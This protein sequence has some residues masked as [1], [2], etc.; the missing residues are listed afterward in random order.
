M[1]RRN[2]D[3]FPGEWVGTEHEREKDIELE[4]GDYA[5]VIVDSQFQDKYIDIQERL[6][7]LEKSLKLILVMNGLIA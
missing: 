1:W 7:K 6:I 4:I 3:I 2:L 5:K